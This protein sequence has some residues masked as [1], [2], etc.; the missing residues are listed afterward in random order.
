M[1]LDEVGVAGALAV[2]V[3]GALH[4]RAARLDRDERVRDRAAGVVVRVDAE[5][6]VERER[7]LAHD[8]QHL[9][10]QRAAVGV[11]EHDRVGAGLG[12]RPAD[13]ERV[14]RV[15]LVAVEEVL[16]VEEDRA[17]RPP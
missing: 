16:G 10:R 7:H 11:A 17:A 6:H 5:R 12:G 8:A 9:V 15:G 1:M 2:A 4:V 14:G 13:L 3:D